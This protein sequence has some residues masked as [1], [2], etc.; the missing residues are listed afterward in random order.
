MDVVYIVRPGDDNE[1][2]RHSLRSLVHVPHDTVWIVGHRPPWVTGVEAVQTIQHGT[3]HDNSTRNLLTACN[4]SAVSDTFLLMMDDVFITH[5]IDHVPV[6]HRGPAADVLRMYELRFR[7]GGSPYVAGMRETYEWLR[8]H[9]HRDP[10]SYE[11]HTPLPV[12]KDGMKRAIQAGIGAGLRVPH[13]RTIYGNLEHIGGTRTCD[14]KIHTK[15]MRPVPGPFVSTMDASFAGGWIGRYLREM[16]P[17][18]GP[19]ERETS[20]TRTRPRHV[21]HARTPGRR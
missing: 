16:F 3:K 21:T 14:V 12:T 8:R 17:D 9:G 19:Y 10:I 2:L 5:P 4:V 18:P 20:F 1:E 11:L 7:R 6:M 13:K 15:E